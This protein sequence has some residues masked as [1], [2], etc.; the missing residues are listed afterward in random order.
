M[1]QLEQIAA[2]KKSREFERKLGHL[3]QELKTVADEELRRSTSLAT[4]ENYLERL[5]LEQG[6]TGVKPGRY[7]REAP[8][9]GDRD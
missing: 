8:P 3:R 1:S 6:R 9:L 7:P 2:V 4:T 5:R